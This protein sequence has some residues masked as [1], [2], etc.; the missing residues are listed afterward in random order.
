LI[1]GIGLGLAVGLGAW[2]ASS[3]R[4][5]RDAT[6]APPPSVPV[7]ADGTIGGVARPA[8]PAYVEAFEQLRRRL[9]SDRATGRIRARFSQWECLE[10]GC[11]AYV[12]VDAVAGESG[13]PSPAAERER[14]LLDHYRGIGREVFGAIAGTPDVTVAPGDSTM[15]DRVALYVVPP[16]TTG[17]DPA[18]QRRIMSKL[19]TGQ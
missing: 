12:D 1:R 9:D 6:G 11:V 3:M 17:A 2:F 13:A 10:Q 5:P 4:R 15:P 19:R 14:A 18:L 16:G 8:P 7:V